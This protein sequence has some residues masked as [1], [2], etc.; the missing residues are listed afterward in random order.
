MR[1]RRWRCLPSGNAAWT[2]IQ[3]RWGEIGSLSLLKLVLHPL[4]VA[5][6]FLMVP[7]QGEIWV[8]VAILSACLPVAAMY[9][10]SACLRG[11]YWQDSNNHPDHNGDCDLP[12][13]SFYM[14]F[15]MG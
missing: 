8:N 15:S 3:R 13:Q 14:L 11:V 2:E 5:C 10:C 9:S 7:G 4:L 12:C 1:R 6:L